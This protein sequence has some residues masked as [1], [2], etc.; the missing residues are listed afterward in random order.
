MLQKVAYR[1]VSKYDTI[2]Y[3]Y[4]NVWLT[5]STHYPHSDCRHG[6]RHRC[7][8][9]HPCRRPVFMGTGSYYPLTRADLTGRIHGPTGLFIQLGVFLPPVNKGHLN[10]SC[11][12]VVRGRAPV[13]RA[14]VLSCLLTGPVEKALSCNMFL[15]TR[16]VNTGALFTLPVQA[17]LTGRVHER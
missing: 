7:H 9:G 10:G 5:V 16:T 12:R 11:S 15:S 8:F 17:V 6:R 13:N 1:S 2:R 14:L 3:D 4:I